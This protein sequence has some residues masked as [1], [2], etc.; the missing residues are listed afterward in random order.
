MRRESSGARMDNVL[1]VV[2]RRVYDE[3]LW[4]CICIACI[5]KLERFWYDFHLHDIW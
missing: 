3:K 5:E 2:L 4:L 1:G